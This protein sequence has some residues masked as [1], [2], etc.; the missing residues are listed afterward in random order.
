MK[1]YS[2]GTFAFATVALASLAGV[3]MADNIASADS[4]N[5][6]YRTRFSGFPG[7]TINVNAGPD[8]AYPA[9]SGL[10]STVLR[11]RFAQGTD[12]DAFANLHYG[13][14]S[15]NGGSSPLGLSANQAF[16]I[17]TTMQVRTNLATTVGAPFNTEGGIWFFQGNNINTAQD[18]GIFVISNGTIFVG[19]AGMDFFLFGEGGFNNPNAPAPWDVTHPLRLTFTY[20]GRPGS[21][22]GTWQASVEDLTTGRF[23]QSPVLGWG[24]S[25]FDGFIDGAL[26]G[27][28]FQN[29]RN[30][31]I[32]T[33]T[34]T[35]YTDTTVTPSPAAAALLGLGGL[36]AGRRRRA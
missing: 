24:T 21:A 28:R 32:A 10:S 7:T 18:G 3:A 19:G 11:E 9:S 34:T 8:N 31:L 14:L 20:S 15:N 13:F 4:F 2:I 6:Q 33:D 30:P 26:A 1:T 36:V 27:V 12:P 16:T 22:A 25:G 17:Q 23:A 29:G 35:S 5:M